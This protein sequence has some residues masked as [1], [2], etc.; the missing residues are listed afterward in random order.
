MVFKDPIIYFKVKDWKQEYRERL[1]DI[2]RKR[3]PGKHDVEDS[4]ANP[5]KQGIQK[6]DDYWL[7]DVDRIETDVQIRKYRDRKKISFLMHSI[8]Q[9]LEKGEGTIDPAKGLIQPLTVDYLVDEDRFKLVTGSCRLEAYRK[10]NLKKIPCRVNVVRESRNHA[11]LILEQYRENMAR[12][13]LKAFEEALAIRELVASGMTQ[14]EAAKKLGK[15]TTVVSRLIKIA[16]FID[17]LPEGLKKVAT[18][19]LIS[20]S[21]L[22]CLADIK[23]PELVEQFLRKPASVKVM[24]KHAER[25]RLSITNPDSACKQRNAIFQ[26]RTPIRV[27]TRLGQAKIK[28]RIEFPAQYHK[29]DVIEALQCLVQ[30]IQGA[31]NQ[32]A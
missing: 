25:S 4:E 19:Q 1:R 3:A 10:L 15:S 8:R 11:E 30:E 26:N 17:G 14:R 22:D 20:Y 31:G 32:S 28:L 12:D 27:S 5:G 29:K 7:V 23:D 2:K 13:D 21:Q 6:L 18:S 9:R 16:E 24:R